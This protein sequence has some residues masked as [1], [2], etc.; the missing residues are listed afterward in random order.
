[1]RY[2]SSAAFRRALEDRLRA[3]SQKTALPLIRLRK[4]VAFDRV[5]ARLTMEQPA[6]CGGFCEIC[7]IC[8][9]TGGPG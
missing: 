6:T 9:P 5:L 3:H 2:A 1:M 8:G 4:L 7:V